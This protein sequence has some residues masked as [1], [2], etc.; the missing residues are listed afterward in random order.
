[1]YF[2]IQYTGMLNEKIR[3]VILEYYYQYWQKKPRSWTSCEH[4]IDELGI[5]NEQLAANL[6]YLVDKGLLEAV[7]HIT[8]PERWLYRIS[9]LG[10]DAVE[11]PERFQNIPF[12]NL[13]LGDVGSVL[14]AQ[15]IR[16]ENGFY[17]VFKLADEL[18]VSN[19]IL[20][21]I[22]EIEKEARKKKP[23]W[24]RIKE[25]MNKVK[26]EEKLF[27][28]LTTVLADVLKNWLK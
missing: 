25:L 3:K 22:K 9:A 17:N 10:I 26:A 2:L 12:I 5:S 4:L 13:F 27:N 14:Q 18:N 7:K 16:I 20:E 24:G 21:A 11:N 1:M 19:E 6:S 23:N 8:S 15:E 28:L